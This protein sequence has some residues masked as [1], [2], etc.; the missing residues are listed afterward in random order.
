MKTRSLPASLR[1]SLVPAALLLGVSALVPAASAQT[2]TAPTVITA[3]PYTISVS[4]KYVLGSDL[5]NTSTTTPAITINVANVNLD[6]GGFYVSGAG[7][8]ASA[9]EV[10]KVGD[11]ANVT[12]KNGTVANDGFGIDFTGTTD[13]RNYVVDSVTFTHC[14]LIGVQFDN[15]VIGGVVRYSKFSD[16]GNSTNAYN[17]AVTGMHTNGGVRIEKNTIDTL[18]AAQGNSST[19]IYS[20]SDNGDFAIGNTIANCDYGI[21]NCT[22]LN[23]LTT[24]IS[25]TSFA[26]GTNASGN[27]SN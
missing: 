21:F 18:T 23:N 1:R 15:P 17:G 6:L 16:L 12:I 26:G 3:V 24:N 5:T 14:Y 11:V 2:V 25:Q 22:Y 20:N 10:I 7:N 13:P 27:T 4:G 19:G 8:R 9:N